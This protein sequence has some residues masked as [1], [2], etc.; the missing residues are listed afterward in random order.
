MLRAVT[1]FWLLLPA[2]SGWLAV[3]LIESWLAASGGCPEAF[4]GAGGKPL[5]GNGKGNLGNDFGNRGGALGVVFETA[6]AAGLGAGTAGGWAAGGV[7]GG[8]AAGAFSGGCAGV[9]AAGGGFCDD[10]AG[11]E[12]G[13][14]NP[15]PLD[16]MQG[17][18]LPLKTCGH[19]GTVLQSHRAASCAAPTLSST[20]RQAWNET[21]PESSPAVFK[22]IYN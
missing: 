9:V 20:T 1:T 11:L 17:V 8:F 14:Q 13:Q 4:G 16:M 7:V 22:F 12:D 18:T 15:M 10:G 21:K 19:C 3:R 2:G 6:G 5:G